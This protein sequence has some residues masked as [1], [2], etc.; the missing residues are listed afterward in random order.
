MVGPYM[1]YLLP[2]L[3]YLGFCKGVSA[4]GSVRP[5]APDT[6]TS[7]ALEATASSSG[8]KLAHHK[9]ITTM[10]IRPLDDPT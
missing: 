7:T 2:L 4:R 3:S 8:K 10:V 5:S 9:V 1:V 6:M